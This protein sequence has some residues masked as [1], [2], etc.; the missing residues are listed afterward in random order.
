MIGKGYSVKTAQIEME[1]IAEGFYATKTIHEL[2][3]KFRVSMPIVDSVYEILYNRCSP[4]MEI[5]KL[6]EQLK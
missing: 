6:S 4:I 1:M 3:E 5:R 2:N